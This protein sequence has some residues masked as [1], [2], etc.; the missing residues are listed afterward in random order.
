M[1]DRSITSALLA[2]H[3]IPIAASRTS[4]IDAYCNVLYRTVPSYRTALRFPFLRHLPLTRLEHLLDP[5]ITHGGACPGRETGQQKQTALDRIPRTHPDHV[6]ASTSL[7]R[8]ADCGGERSLVYLLKVIARVSRD[9]F[10][11]GG[12]CVGGLVAASR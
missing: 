10:R 4:L 9:G 1:R 12:A 2:F 11:G 3:F 5:R 6:Y 7:S 8:G